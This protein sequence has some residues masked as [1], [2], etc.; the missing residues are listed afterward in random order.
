MIGKASDFIQ[1]KLDV[2]GSPDNMVKLPPF[3][4]LLMSLATATKALDQSDYVQHSVIL[5]R[6]GTSSFMV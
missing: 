6:L 1:G 4:L 3:T 2:T 5:D